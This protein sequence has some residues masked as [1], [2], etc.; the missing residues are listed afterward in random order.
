MLETLWPLLLFF[1]LSV[2]ALLWLAR[3]QARQ[4]QQR[5]DSL[6]MAAVSRGWTFESQDTGR[7]HT[8]RWQGVTDGT[9][10][11]LEYRHH[12]KSKR[13]KNAHSHRVVWW[14]DTFRGP[15]SPVLFI[16]VPADAENPLLKLAQSEGVLA[17][18]VQKAAGFALDKALDAHFGEEAGRQ[19][20]ARLL[21]PVEASGVRG[22]MVMAVDA[23]QATW[24]LADG[25]SKS[26]SA[27]PLD[28]LAT[29]TDRLWVLVLPRRAY[30]ARSAPIRTE[31][32]VQAMVQAGLALVAHA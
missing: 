24:M 9:R 2:G 4:R 19:V 6:R 29:R 22:F 1:A 23:A 18:M 30:L 15:T 26:L 32:D 5:E 25:W 21:K 8:L 3:R 14:A 13:S 10:W 27:L 7:L 28:S 12:R 31:E 16:G 11:T 17:S 20:D